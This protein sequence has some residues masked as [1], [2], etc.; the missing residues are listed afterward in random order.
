MNLKWQFCEFRNSTQYPYSKL[1][2][3]LLLLLGNRILLK[4]KNNKAYACLGFPIAKDNG[5]NSISLF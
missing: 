3:G 1:S 5:L 2:E 4:G